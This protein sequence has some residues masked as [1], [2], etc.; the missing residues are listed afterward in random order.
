MISY[1][2]KNGFVTTA[3]GGGVTVPEGAKEL[4]EKQLASALKREQK[5]RDEK[6]KEA[7]EVEAKRIGTIAKMVKAGKYSREEAEMI[8][9][10]RLPQDDG[11]DDD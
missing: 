2:D 9:R 6:Q 11:N 1:Q 4:S 3:K 7:A 10:V 5:A 8:F